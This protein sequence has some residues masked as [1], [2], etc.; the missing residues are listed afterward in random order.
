MR[1]QERKGEMER[2]KKRRDG[3]RIEKERWKENRKGE[4]ER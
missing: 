4:M 3:K 2:Q 1:D